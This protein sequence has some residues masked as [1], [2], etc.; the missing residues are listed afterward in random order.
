MSE[1][2][3]IGDSTFAEGLET[4]VTQRGTGVGTD[5]SP[6]VDLRTGAVAQT[7]FG[8]EHVDGG[9]QSLDTTVLA[10]TGRLNGGLGETGHGGGEASAEASSLPSLSHA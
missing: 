10:P 1:T 5:Q 6:E 9:L 7:L 2:L 4:L 3:G 8:L